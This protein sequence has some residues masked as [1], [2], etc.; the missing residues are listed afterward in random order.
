MIPHLHWL[1]QSGQP[2]AHL[3]WLQAQEITTTFPSRSTTGPPPSGPTRAFKPPGPLPPRPLIGW[4]NGNS[5]SAARPILAASPPTPAARRS[6]GSSRPRQRPMRPRIHPI[7]R[8]V[9]RTRTDDEN[10]RRRE[11]HPWQ[12][13]RPPRT[14]LADQRGNVSPG[15][16]RLSQECNHEIGSVGDVWPFDGTAFRS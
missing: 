2:V 16:A 15:Q 7:R 11:I 1:S 3:S 8:P 6:R 5:R 12:T 13:E 10:P 14:I 9:G 4:N